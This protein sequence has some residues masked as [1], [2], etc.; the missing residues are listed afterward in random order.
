MTLRSLWP[1]AAIGAALAAGGGLAW[2]THPRVARVT[3]T[4]TPTAAGAAVRVE[5]GP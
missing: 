3:V 5:V 4:V 1:L 2:A